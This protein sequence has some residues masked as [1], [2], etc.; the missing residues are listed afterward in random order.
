MVKQKKDLVGGSSD[1][2]YKRNYQVHPVEEGGVEK[3]RPTNKSSKGGGYKKRVIPSALKHAVWVHYNGKNFESKCCISWCKNTINVF[4]FEAGHDYPESKG[5]ATTLENL[6]PI[7][8]SCNKSMGNRYTIAEFSHV[9]GGGGGGS[10]GGGCG[11]TMG[12]QE[13]EGG[14]KR[15]EEEPPIAARAKWW[16]SLLTC[17]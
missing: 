1:G 9:F 14:G 7:C 4:S 6:R 16:H 11:A 12:L 5:G 3:V 15:W 2:M 10:E 17:K 13:E 8:S